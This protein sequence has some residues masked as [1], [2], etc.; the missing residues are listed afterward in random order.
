MPHAKAIPKGDGNSDDFQNAD[1]DN[2]GGKIKYVFSLSPLAQ[3]TNAYKSW[4]D[5]SLIW[6]LIAA[7]T[8]N[9]IVK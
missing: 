9:P 2:L 8:D 1:D 3:H 4:R 6:A 5:L 7:I